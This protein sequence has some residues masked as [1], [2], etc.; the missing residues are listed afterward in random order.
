LIIAFNIWFIL[1]TGKW[2][3][4]TGGWWLANGG[5]WLV[6]GNKSFLYSQPER[7]KTKKGAQS[8]FPGNI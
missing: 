4:A 3:L 6:A 8:P 5:W 1:A 2:R 7:H